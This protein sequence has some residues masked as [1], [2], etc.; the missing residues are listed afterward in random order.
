[1]SEG[2]RDM[3]G[4]SERRR[5]CEKKGRRMGMRT[6]VRDGVRE[7]VRKEGSEGDRK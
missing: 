4:V 7:G 6:G 2:V 1:M 5:E 3:E